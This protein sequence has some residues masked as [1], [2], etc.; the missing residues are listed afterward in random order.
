MSIPIPNES[1]TISGK[2]SEDKKLRMKVIPIAFMLI[3]TMIATGCLTDEDTI[4]VDVEE[5][6]DEMTAEYQP[7]PT[8]WNYQLASTATTYVN[9]NSSLELEVR[10]ENVVVWSAQSIEYQNMLIT[11]HANGYFED[12]LSPETLEFRARGLDGVNVSHNDFIFLPKR[13]T[14]EGC[15]LWDGGYNHYGRGTDTADVG[16]DIEQNNFSAREVELEWRIPQ[17]NFGKPYTLEIQAVVGG[18]AE[19]V[20]ATV[21]VHIDL[22]SKIESFEASTDSEHYYTSDYTSEEE[23]AEG[24]F[25]VRP[26]LNY[27]FENLPGGEDSLY[28]VEIYARNFYRGSGYE[29]VQNESDM[30]AGEDHTA[31]PTIPIDEWGSDMLVILRFVI[32]SQESNWVYDSLEDEEFELKF[33]VTIDGGGDV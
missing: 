28:E 12:E 31:V 3:F 5:G 32:I 13:G 7:S 18:F 29:M 1:D 11:V 23:A 17:S 22:F 21:R 25:Y 8:G 33:T 6:F 24:N 4:S 20:V 27:R 9:E 19:E 30:K 10:V 14:Y 15:S 26:E 2:I 16:S